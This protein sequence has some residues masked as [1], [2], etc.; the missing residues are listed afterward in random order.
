VNGSSR[1]K[2]QHH[3]GST[4]ADIAPSTN[5]HDPPD[6]SR[7]D[8]KTFEEMA[9]A[10]LDK[11]PGV[12]T[13]DLFRTTFDAQYGVDATGEIEDGL[14]VQSCKCYGLVRKGQLAQWSQDFLDHWPTYWMQRRVRKFILVVAAPMNSRPRLDDIE[15]ERA[16]FA[17]I[18]VVYEVW[19]QRQIQERIRAHRGLVSQYLGGA[20]WVERLCGPA[21]SSDGVA[22]TLESDLGARIAD[23]G[24]ALSGL[25]E[26][27]LKT[28]TLAVER[29]QAE[30]LDQLLRELRGGSAWENLAGAQ[31][32]QIVRLQGSAA[33]NRGDVSAAEAFSREADA[34]A[35]P[36]EPRL[37]A[38]VAMHRSGNEAALSVLGAPVTSK[39][40][41]LRAGLLLNL[42]RLEDFADCLAHLQADDPETLRLLG[43]SQLS[44]GAAS[45]ALATLERAF[46]RTPDAP[47]I[48]RMLATAL[49]ANALS[50]LAPADLYLHPQPVNDALVGEDDAA[51]ER[52]SRAHQLFTGLAARDPR[53]ATHELDALWSLASLA[54]LHD[55]HAEA[56]VLAQD[57]LSARPTSVYAIGWVLARDLDVDLSPSRVALEAALRQGD[58]EVNGP[59]ALEWLTPPSDRAKLAVAVNAAIARGGWPADVADEIAKLK[60][61][62]EDD[63]ADPARANGLLVFEALQND[64][65]RPVEAAYAALAARDPTAPPV[66]ALAEALAGA[67]R[68][69]CLKAE[70]ATLLAFDT[71]RA[72]R[73][74]AYVAYNTGEPETCRRILQERVHRFA[75]GRLP[76]DLRALEAEALAA[77]G[78]PLDALDRA[79]AIALETRAT[80]DILREARLRQ[81]IGDLRGAVPAVRGVLE[82]GAMAAEDALSWSEALIGEEPDLAQALWR[83]AT[84]T[85]LDDRTAVA[86]LNLG[87]ALGLEDERPELMAAL[88]RLADQGDAAVQRLEFNDVVARLVEGRERQDQI[89]DLYTRGRVPAHLLVAGAGTN[90][91]ELL[92]LEPAGERP[93]RPIFLRSGARPARPAADFGPI[94]AWRLYLDVTALLIG[95]QLGL[96]PILETLEAPLRIAGSTMAALQEI[97]TSARHNQP[98]RGRNAHRILDALDG[99][100]STTPLAEAWSVVHDPSDQPNAVGLAEVVDGLHALK[101][102]DKT[103]LRRVRQH[104]NLPPSARPPPDRRQALTFKDQTLD[105]LVGVDLLDATLSNFRVAIDADAHAEAQ[106]EA[107]ALDRGR[108]LSERTAK[109]RRRLARQLRLGRYEVVVPS[110]AQEPDEQPDRLGGG[111]AGRALGEILRAASEDPAGRLWVEDRLLSSYP[112]SGQA[113]IIGTLEVLDALA[114]AELLDGDEA[115]AKRLRLREAGGLFLPLSVEEVQHHLSAAPIRDGVVVET[116]ELAILRRSVNFALLH[117]ERL[118]L[119]PDDPAAPQAGKDRPVELE[120]PMSARRLAELTILACWNG[121][122]TA[123][124]AEARSDWI[125]GALRSDTVLRPKAAQLADPGG[126]MMAALNLASLVACGFNIAMGSAAKSFARR[127]AFFDWVERSAIADRLERDPDLLEET[128]ALTRSF[129][130]LDSEEVAKLDGPQLAQAQRQSRIV[131]SQITGR[132]GAAVRADRAFMDSLGLAETTVISLHDKTFLASAFWGAL[133]KAVNGEVGH[134]PAREDGADCEFRASPDE[135]DVIL[136]GGALDGQIRVPALGLL[137]AQTDRRRQSLATFL[138]LIDASAA[139]REAL[140][141]ELSEPTP[142]ERL[143]T[144]VRALVEQSPPGFFEGLAS[145]LQGP[146]PLTVARFLPP[147]VEI[148]LDALRWSDDGGWTQDAASALA[149][150]V[151]ARG[152]IARLASQPVAIPD[153]LFSQSKDG[154]PRMITPLARLHRLR[155]LRTGALVQPDLD[156]PGEVEK[157]LGAFEAWG[158]LFCTLLRWSARAFQA[159]PAWARLSAAARHAAVWSFSDGLID[160]FATIGADPAAMLPPFVEGMPAVSSARALNLTRGYEDSAAA[161]AS[162]SPGWL[163]LAG[164]EHALGPAAD[165][166]QL[167]PKQLERLRGQLGAYNDGAYVPR[168]VRCLAR[169]A[170]ALETWLNRPTPLQV[171]EGGD[172]LE[173]MIDETLDALD[174]PAPTVDAWR[175]LFVFGPPALSQA[176]T[177]RLSQILEVV[178]PVLLTTLSAEPGVVLR[179]VAETAGRL[180]DRTASQAFLTAMLENLDALLDGATAVGV[181]DLIEAGASAAMDFDGLGP[182]RFARFVSSLIAR[183]P[184]L[185]ADLRPVLQRLADSSPAAETDA[186]RQVLVGALVF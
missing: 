12:A 31:Q 20:D 144:R 180:A 178:D 60:A 21:S 2:S 29:G 111:A 183:R 79:A 124:V 8:A 50:P 155:A 64:D 100:L 18:D 116:R 24:Q 107:A 75:G 67:S 78:K 90:L 99:R 157:V 96:L 162:M 173:A 69:P 11:E 89:V 53:L 42:G 140:R 70:I 49:Y 118:K 101:V 133:T 28:V 135:A 113:Q 126:L 181:E 37:R 17:A 97:E 127:A 44:A 51:R 61:R 146:K 33:L 151:G 125:W 34:L 65:W 52:L 7:M 45:E 3:V 5:R 16:R 43:H 9:C 158:E 136:L 47:A 72:I 163:L 74:A 117:Q 122:A 152:A 66:L 82:Q 104:L 177:Q 175:F 25:L 84:Q 38:L 93:P 121:P 109:L 77:L 105:L 129:L 161:A 102:I 40:W 176:Q 184:S 59:R 172:R 85:D 166:L 153:A 26:E 156:L 154:P 10:L 123:Q 13:A 164:L 186:F 19:A 119:D 143:M 142:P 169:A 112:A 182:E 1:D 131:V 71:A 14:I 185:A 98:S 36:E 15:R 63:R 114:A 46:A 120:F 55:R 170:P 141:L 148:F 41:S 159:Q 6:F 174:G 62:L 171:D 87:F 76:F 106:S 139:R 57:I 168:P 150:Q 108:R 167:S 83:H 86:A 149:E 92:S 35:P 27:R 165:T 56:Q 4:A 68:W 22:A 137:S 88:H 54:N 58:L 91:A 115:Y 130:S 81:G 48:Q 134:A 103:R 95:D 179:Q 30:P 147:P 39:G 23:L 128:A 73:I 132:L 160:M 145:A 110:P 80:D 94:Q 138:E 32:A